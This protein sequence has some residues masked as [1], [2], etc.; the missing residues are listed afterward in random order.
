MLKGTVASFHKL[1]RYCVKRIASFIKSLVR[2]QVH[3]CFFFKLLV[4][5][6]AFEFLPLNGLDDIFTGKRR[7][8][9]VKKRRFVVGNTKGDLHR[10]MIF[11]FERGSTYP[12]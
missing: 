7:R 12:S 9:N 1:K 3:F 6:S 8:F 10:I 11:D 2:S 4:V 5:C